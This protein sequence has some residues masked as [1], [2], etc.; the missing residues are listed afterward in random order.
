V[1]GLLLL[2]V[3]V[4]ADAQG[5]GPLLHEFLP[6]DPA[7]DMSM[8]STNSTGDFPGAVKTPSGTIAPPDVYNTAAPDRVYREP[9]RQQAGFRPDRD[10]SRPHV[11][12]YDDPF[13]PSLTPFK[14]M[15]A[16][17]AVRSDYSLYVRDT[18]LRRVLAEPA[19][20]DASERFFG[21]MAVQLRSGENVRIPTVG[22]STRLHELVAHPA[23]SVTVWRDGA[24][25]WFARGDETR[26]VRLITELSIAR[27]TFGSAFSDV[28]W[29]A[30]PRVPA[31]PARH[32]NAYQR[33]ARHIG[34]SRSNAP[35][36]VVLKLVEYFRS[37]EPSNDPPPS[38]GDIYLDLALSKKGVCRHRAFAF[39]VTALNIGIPTR[40][41]H[42][43]AHA[44]VEVNDGHVWHRIDL[45]GAALDLDDDTR[46]DRPAHRAPPDPYRWPSG[47]DSGADLADRVRDAANEASSSAA[48]DP[49][50]ANPA[51]TPNPTGATTPADPNDARP[52]TVVTIDR[53]DADTFRGL[54]M[55]LRGTVRA[56][57][58]G[59]A[60][61]RVD[62]LLQM[63][64]EE[65]RLGSL[66]TNDAGVYDGAVVLP[67]DVPIG[68][69]ELVVVTAG[70]QRCGPGRGQ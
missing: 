49:A 6:P 24:D 13:T 5:S 16:F 39:L 23:T 67:P 2:A 41:V 63:S 18:A 32:R 7:E 51:T 36:E 27:D 19:E 21:D 64:A 45:G 56:E 28:G 20:K 11:E 35:T 52:R 57:G 17:D 34:I 53:V 59:C 22:P 69:H 12:N 50:V 30:L 46:L 31:Q 15:Y 68:D 29:A 40:M 60:N 25:N 47:R 3:T 62:V 58:R 10:T 54:P 26:K 42:N 70:N 55:K 8:S 43:E 65:L 38:N 61:L 1:G 4:R 37:F 48:R 14:R 66:S 9:D 44:W 33:V